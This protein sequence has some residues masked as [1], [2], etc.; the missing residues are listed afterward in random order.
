VDTRPAHR[1]STT[2]IGV[3]DSGLGTASRPGMTAMRV[4]R[5]S[6]ATC[7]GEKTPPPLARDQNATRRPPRAVAVRLWSDIAMP[8]MAPNKATFRLV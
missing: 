8:S 3:M 5:M 1:E 4:A 7:G 2:A 6:A